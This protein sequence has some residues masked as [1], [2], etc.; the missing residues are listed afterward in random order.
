MN[1][2]HTLYDALW[3][4]CSWVRICEV[5]MYNE[6]NSNPNSVQSASLI[7]TCI[8]WYN[9]KLIETRKTFATSPLTLHLSFSS[10]CSLICPAFFFFTYNTCFM[11]FALS[12]RL[13]TM[14]Q[15]SKQY[16]NSMN[17]HYRYIF[18]YSLFNRSKL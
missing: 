2:L 17:N 3:T 11:Q 15:S 18:N 14:F 13:L 8:L 1:I 9:T 4:V 7:G 16:Y 5:L 6:N 12:K 10:S